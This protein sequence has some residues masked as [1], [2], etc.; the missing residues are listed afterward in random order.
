M[1]CAHGLGEIILPKSII[2]KEVY[3]FHANPSQNTNDTFHITRAN[4]SKICMEKW[5]TSN[6]KKKKNL[7]KEE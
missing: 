1:L 3:R 4:N 2:P 6:R 5:N 7:E